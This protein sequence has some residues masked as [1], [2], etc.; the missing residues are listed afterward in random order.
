ME[1]VAAKQRLAQGDR[2]FQLGG[3]AGHERT[4]LLV[5]E[6]QHRYGLRDLLALQIAQERA[7]QMAL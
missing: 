2:H 7:E 5:R 4:Y 3:Q 6:R 1:L